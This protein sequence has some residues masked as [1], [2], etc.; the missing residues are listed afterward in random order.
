MAFDYS[1]DLQTHS[2]FNTL[3]K[4]KIHSTSE[5]I[6]EPAQSSHP[7]GIQQPAVP[8]PDHEVGSPAFQYVPSEAPVGNGSDASGQPPPPSYNST[9]V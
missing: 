8:G 4:Q 7:V 3:E 6:A 5:P 9:V 1:V 2:S